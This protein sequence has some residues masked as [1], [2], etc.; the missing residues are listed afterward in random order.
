MGTRRT[1]EYGGVVICAT[2]PN[3]S[4]VELPQNQVIIM[5]IMN[6]DVVSLVELID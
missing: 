1:Q 6:E 3:Y 4:D 5:T 2:P